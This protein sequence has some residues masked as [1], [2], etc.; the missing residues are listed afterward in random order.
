[1]AWHGGAWRGWAGR[2][3]AG[4]GDTRQGI[5]KSIAAWQVEAGQCWAGRVRVGS[6]KTRQGINKLEITMNKKLTF[7]KSSDTKILESVLGEAKIGQMVTYEELSTAIGRDVRKFALPSLRSARR[8]LLKS[9]D[10][11]FGCESGVGL[12]RLNDSQI[13]DSAE[14]DRKRMKRAATRSLQKLSVVDFETLPPV[15]KKQH[16]VAAA[17]MG[18]IAMFSSTSSRKRIEASVNESKSTL[19]IGETLSLFK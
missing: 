10:F 15:K 5:N 11:V 6:S 3:G 18:A 17:Q 9:K 2:G 12:R 7:E 1:M 8:G 14:D 4:P 16:T 19:A 13:I